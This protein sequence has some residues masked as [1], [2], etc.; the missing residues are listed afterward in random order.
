MI[1]PSLGGGLKLISLDDGFEV[2]EVAPR[3]GAWIETAVS[4]AFRHGRK[5]RPPYGAWIET[6]RT[7]TNCG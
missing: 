7:A 3:T 1:G 2:A 6:M 5:G 4:V